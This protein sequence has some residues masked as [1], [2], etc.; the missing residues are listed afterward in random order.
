MTSAVTQQILAGVAGVSTLTFATSATS[1][2]AAL[3]IP[4]DAA[5]GDLAVVCDGYVNGSP[6]AVPSGWTACRA[7]T[8]AT[9]GSFTYNTRT[10]YRVLQAGDAGAAI[11][12]LTGSTFR[13]AIAVFR[14]GAGISSVTLSSWSGQSVAGAPTNQ[15]IPALGQTPP[16]LLIG[17]T[18]FGLNDTASL[19]MN[20]TENGTVSTTKVVLKYKIY[21][22][23]ET[24]ANNTVSGA[25]SDPVTG[26][27]SGYFLV[28]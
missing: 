16:I 25:A 6:Q 10:M 28:T 15:T 22:T 14:R 26:M 23:G 3:S 11:T 27:H 13:R 21:N 9:S 19:T 7:A 20:P 1:T 4:A 12:A 18:V 8:A 24:P 5:T 17:C 2:N